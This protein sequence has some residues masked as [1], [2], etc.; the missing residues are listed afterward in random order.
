MRSPG[1]G[2]ASTRG[3]GSVPGM[4][5]VIPL[6]V[7]VRVMLVN[8]TVMGGEHDGWNVAVAV[9]LK[10]A[11]PFCTGKSAA[12]LTLVLLTAFGWLPPP[13]RHS[14]VASST[15]W[16]WSSSPRPASLPETLSVLPD[17]E[18]LSEVWMKCGLPAQALGIATPSTNNA[19]MTA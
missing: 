14:A 1:G 16:T 4:L 11:L 2:A 9:R 7:S 5:A 12:V 15:T 10:S 3:Y 18:A 17:A 8:E 19:D 6:V 13:L